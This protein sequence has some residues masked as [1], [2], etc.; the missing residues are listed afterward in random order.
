M[1]VRYSRQADAAQYRAKSAGRNRVEVFN[2]QLRESLEQRLDEEQQVRRAI[3]NGEIVAWFQPIV[4]LDTGRIIAA[5]ALARW[6]HPTRGMLDAS[7]FV[8]LIEESGLIITLDDRMIEQA[9]EAATQLAAIAHGTDFRIW[10]NA[11]ANHFSR[12]N[13][14]ELFARLLERTGCDGETIGF[15]IT[16]TALLQD[17]HVAS[18]E[19]TLARELGIKTA[20][21]DF[22]VG[23]S[24]LTLLRSLPI[25]EVKIDRSFIRDITRDPT[26]ATVVRS[27]TFLAN[28]LG[29]DAVAEGVETPEQAHLLRDFGCRH[30]Q[31]YLWAR[32]MP[33]E[34]LAEQLRTTSTTPK[35]IAH[36]RAPE[37][38]TELIANND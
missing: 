17:L 31:G 30:A 26:A 10:C 8:P 34:Q 5:E 1:Q 2:L 11:S 4:D 24:S 29:I 33:I 13:P 6:L 38:I 35:L 15:E 16:E 14:T 32:A 27:V 23:Y 25:D 21:D 36:R 19:L 22:G 20:L 18:Q 7:K 37:P 3:D 9:V 12:S 28:G